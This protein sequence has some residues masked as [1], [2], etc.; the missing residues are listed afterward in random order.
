MKRSLLAL[1]LL[2][3]AGS[4]SAQMSMPNFANALSTYVAGSPQFPGGMAAAGQNFLAG[5]VTRGFEAGRNG[6]SGFAVLSTEGT[7]LAP[8]GTTAEQSSLDFYNTLLPL[9]LAMDEPAMQLAAMGTPVTVP[10]SGALGFFASTF[11]VFAT[12]PPLPG[13][14]SN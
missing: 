14:P 4:A 7:P 1:A 5:N 13:L 6:F 3:A 11:K 10:V 12:N 9:Y 2:A 8:L